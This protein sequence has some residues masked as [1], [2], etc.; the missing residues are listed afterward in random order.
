MGQGVS[1]GQGR[2]GGL[3]ATKDAKIRA[4]VVEDIKILEKEFEVMV[5]KFVEKI[6]EV[7]EYRKKEIVVHDVKV[8]P[9]EVTAETVKLVERKVPIDK[10]VYIDVTVEVPV[11]KKKEIIEPI[12]IQHETTIEVPRVIEKVRIEERVVPI[13]KY[14]LVEEMVK[15]PKIVYVPTTVE[16]IVWKDVPRERCKHCSKEI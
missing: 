12:I 10:P 3:R 5:P 9:V 15:V 13:T 1:P 11:F 14:K 8:L 7:P 6:I 2:T 4:L 16:R